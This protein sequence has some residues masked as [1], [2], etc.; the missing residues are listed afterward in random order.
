MWTVERCFCAVRRYSPD[1][2]SMAQGDNV[3]P[4]KWNVAQQH[5]PCSRLNY[6]IYIHLYASKNG[7]FSHIFPLY[8]YIFTTH[9]FPVL[10]RFCISDNRHRQTILC[11]FWRE[12]ESMIVWCP[13]LGFGEGVGVL[14]A[15]S[16]HAM[17]WASF[18]YCT[19]VLK[20]LKKIGRDCE[21]KAGTSCNVVLNACER[22]S[23]WQRAIEV[24][25]TDA[26]LV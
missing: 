16:P 7:C 17:H 22:V 3:R 13:L 24:E 8:N 18:N 23:Q 12:I 2:C 4:K 6:I 25:A 9:E 10:W 14:F 21:S 20:D 15:D 11:V 19:Q 1:Q 26:A 5:E